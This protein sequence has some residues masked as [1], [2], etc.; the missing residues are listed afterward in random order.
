[1]LLA[2]AHPRENP[3]KMIHDKSSM[4]RRPYMSLS[5][6]RQTEKPRQHCQKCGSVLDCMSGKLTHV[7]Q[8]IRQ[9]DPGGVD[10]V[11]QFVRYC[12]QGSRHDRGVETGKQ[13]ADEKPAR[14]M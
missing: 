10:E 4:F 11:V 12:D 13:Q 14:Y 3:M 8:Q 7:R 1:M 9:D 2:E 6:E 5:L